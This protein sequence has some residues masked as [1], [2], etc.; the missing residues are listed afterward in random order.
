MIVEIYTRALPFGELPIGSGQWIESGAL[1]LLEQLAPADAEFAHGPLV[2]ALHDEHDGGVAFGERKENPPAQSPEN[3]GLRK[4]HSRFDF[5]LIAG[6]VGARRE[7][8]DGIMK[9]HGAIG[10]VDLGV[11]KR[12]L[13]DAALQIV[14]NQQFRH[15]AKEPEHSHVRAGPVRQLLRPGRLRISEV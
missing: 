3:I 15:A 7:N 13:V 10:A 5:R 14:G 8:A 12:G 9:R 2:H 4:S 6:L 11:V 1:D